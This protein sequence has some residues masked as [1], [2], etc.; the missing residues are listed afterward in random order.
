MVRMLDDLKKVINLI[1]DEEEGVRILIKMIF[2][3][4]IFYYVFLMDF[5]NLR[6]LVCM[7]FVLF[8]EEMYKIKYDL[9]DFFY[10]DEDLLVS[11]LIYCYFDCVLFFV[12]N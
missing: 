8:F 5:D 7:Q 6:C 1:E 2:L 3:N 4:I 12:I 11:G 9:E 10:E